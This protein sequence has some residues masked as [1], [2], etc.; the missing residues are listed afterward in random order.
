MH[1]YQW[2]GAHYEG[3]PGFNFYAVEYGALR[4]VNRAQAQNSRYE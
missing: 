1:G 3:T 4:D 2:A